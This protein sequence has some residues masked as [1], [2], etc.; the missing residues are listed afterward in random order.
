MPVP[1]KD[2]EKWSLNVRDVPIELYWYFHDASQSEQKEF[3]EWVLE[4]LKKAAREKLKRGP[5]GKAG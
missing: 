3:K 5:K 4:S 1:K 2:A